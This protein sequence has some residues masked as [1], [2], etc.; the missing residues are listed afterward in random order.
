MTVPPET[1]TLEELARRSIDGDRAAV[2]ALVRALQVDVFGLAL[3][4]LWQRESAED[5]TQEILV[6]VITRLAQFDFRSRLTTWVY[7]VATNYLLDVKRS[8]VERM[9]LTFDRF[10]D[11]LADG[12]ST[13][14]P[15]EAERS[16]LTEEVKIGCTLGMLQCL[17]RPHRLAYILGEVL[18]LPPGEAAEALAVEP[19]AFRKR[20]ERARRRVEAFAR[21]HCGIVSDQAACRCHLRVPAAVQI[22]RVRPGDPQ[23]AESARSFAEARDAVRRLDHARQV[24]ELHRR[25]RPR[26]SSID[27]ARRIAAAL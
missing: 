26:E 22:G 8:P 23:F 12:L 14:G 17:D 7:R 4:M 16:V 3:R 11:D 6:R 5:A 10:A 21:Q 2:E 24:L 1:P 25:S 27:F 9:Q 20:L 15:A 18:E 13:D 19:A